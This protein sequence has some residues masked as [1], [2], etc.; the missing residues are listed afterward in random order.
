MDSEKIDTDLF[1]KRL[2]ESFSSVKRPNRIA[3]SCNHI[4]EERKKIESHFKGMDRSA[5]TYY[6]ASMMLI[7]G[8]LIK[9]KSYLYFLPRI[10]EFVLNGDA[11]IHFLSV[12]MDDLIEIDCLTHDQKNIL[13]ELK[14][15]LSFLD[16]QDSC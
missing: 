14:A 15:F 13:I 7:D 9:P 16:K 12:R 10:V 11:D 8:A 6:D 1:L 3:T 4:D 2:W 5:M